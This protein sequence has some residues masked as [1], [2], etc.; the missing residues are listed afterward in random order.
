[1]PS[2]KQINA[3]MGPGGSRR[4]FCNS[5]H[6]NPKYYEPKMVP[7]PEG[8]LVRVGRNLEPLMVE[9]MIPVVTCSRFAGHEGDCAAYAFHIKAPET[10]E[11]PEG[12]D[13]QNG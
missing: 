2:L 11:K 9:A 5:P 1:M 13:D 10:W 7:H 8:K 12:W 3:K 6:P 4:G